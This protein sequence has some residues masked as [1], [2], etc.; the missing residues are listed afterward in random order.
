VN[1]FAQT[2]FTFATA[3]AFA[4]F[5][6]AVFSVSGYRSR[7]PITRFL[8][9]VAAVTLIPIVGPIVWLARYRRAYPPTAETLLQQSKR[10]GIR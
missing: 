10:P 6:V 9:W 1:E 7:M 3:L 2:A 8:L 4:L 5:L